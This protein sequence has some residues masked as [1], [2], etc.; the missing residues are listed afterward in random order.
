MKKRIALIATAALCALALCLC[1]IP[2][3][4]VFAEGAEPTNVALHKTAFVNNG[5]SIEAYTADG[6]GVCALTDGVQGYGGWIGNFNEVYTSEDA[7]TILTI[8]LGTSYDLTSVVVKPYDGPAFIAYIMPLA[9]TVEVYD[10]NASE[11]VVVGE[12]TACWANNTANPNFEHERT[13]ELVYELEE[14]ITANKVRM[15]ITQDSTCDI[16]VPAMLTVVGEIEAYG[17]LAEGA[18]LPAD[19]V[20]VSGGATAIV[21]NGNSIEAPNDGWSVAFLTDGDATTAWHGDFNNFNGSSLRDKTVLLIDLG[22]VY[23]IGAVN[24]YPYAGG[25]YSAVIMPTEY[26]IEVYSNGAWVEVASDSEVYVANGVN[27]DPARVPIAEVLT[28]TFDTIEASQVR[29]VITADSYCDLGLASCLTVVG[30]I[31]VLGYADS[32]GDAPVVTETQAPT[33]TETEA[34]EVTE[35]EAPEETV[36][37]SDVESD[38]ESVEESDTTVETVVDETVADTGV[39]ET[40]AETTAATDAPA[41]DAE[42]GCASVVGFGAVAVLAAAAAAVVLK[43]KD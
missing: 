15:V 33:V 9:Y 12:E 34:P 6:W 20:C 27:S 14:T 29:M 26:T 19:L 22:A 10:V 31:E 18:E 8:D 40:V 23:E 39:E 28:Y 2:A 21:T 37:E 38:V 43:K 16:G 24:V 5:N 41:A 25:A 32:V 3:I 42:E 30:E 1:A 36:V 4:S 17:T 35:T 7:P 13:P 11:W